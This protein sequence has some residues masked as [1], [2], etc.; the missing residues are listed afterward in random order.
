[1]DIT[2]LICSENPHLLTNISQYITI[3]C[4]NEWEYG[5]VQVFYC[6]PTFSAGHHIPYEKHKGLIVYTYIV[7]I[8]IYI[9]YIV[10]Y[11]YII[12]NINTAWWLTYPSEKYDFVSWD[13]YSQKIWGNKNVPNHQPVYIWAN[14]NNSLT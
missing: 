1:M 10:I 9:L 4:E 14:Y 13:Y 2:V 8:Y 3:F 5:C 11:I 6:I 7:C 12:I